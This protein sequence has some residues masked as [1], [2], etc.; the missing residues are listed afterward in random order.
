MEDGN[1]RVVFPSEE[2]VKSYFPDDVWLAMSGYEKMSYRNILHNYYVMKSLDLKPKKPPFL[3]LYQKRTFKRKPNRNMCPVSPK[4]KPSMRASSVNKGMVNKGTEQEKEA[5][6]VS[7]EQKTKQ[8]NTEVQ[9][10]LV[11]L[12]DENHRWQS[13]RAHCMLSAVFKVYK[14]YQGI[15]KARFSQKRTPISVSNKYSKDPKEE[16]GKID[17]KSNIHPNLTNRKNKEVEAGD[18]DNKEREDEN[19]SLDQ[20]KPESGQ[21]EEKGIPIS[22]PAATDEEKDKKNDEEKGTKKSVRVTLPRTRPVCRSVQTMTVADGCSPSDSALVFVNAATAKK[23]AVAP[24]KPLPLTDEQKKLKKKILKKKLRNCRTIQTQTVE[25]NDQIETA[26]LVFFPKPRVKKPK[27]KPSTIAAPN[28]EEPH[29]DGEQNDDSS[30]ADHSI[31]KTPNSTEAADTNKDI[32]VS[33]AD[34]PCTSANEKHDEDSSEDEFGFYDLARQ[35]KEASRCI[36]NLSIQNDPDMASKDKFDG[37]SEDEFGFYDL[38][39]LEK[40][41]RYPRRAVPV[42]NYK[43]SELVQDDEYLFCDFCD[44]EYEGD[45][46]EHGPHKY[47]PDKDIPVTGDRERAVETT[48]DM[49]KIGKSKIPGAGSGV[50]TILGL[51]PHVR[52]GP[53]QGD[54][55]SE[56]DPLGY[57]WAI[58]KDRKVDHYIA[59]HS[60]ATSNWMRFVN[61]ARHESEQNLMAFQYKGKMYYRTVKLIPPKAELFVWYGKEYAEMLGISMESFRSKDT[62]HLRSECLVLKPGIPKAIDPQITPSG[63]DPNTQSTSL[64][65]KPNIT[66][67]PQ[68]FQKEA[69]L[70][71][72]EERRQKAASLRAEHPTNLDDGMSLGAPPKGLAHPVVH[73]CLVFS[74]E[75]CNITYSSPLY[76][77][78]HEKKC[79]GKRTAKVVDPSRV[80]ADKQSLAVVVDGPQY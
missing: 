45:C 72:D 75:K 28:T 68:G 25:E 24:P 8:E 7:K 22:N 57:S 78:A 27:P 52:F 59:A 12:F 56:P 34:G 79:R 31:I 43:E 55:T 2:E 4:R 29:K 48:P 14:R 11:E 73:N 26:D 54:N 32:K 3:T 10:K 44:R 69:G 71:A 74:C 37:S 9:N 40:E 33:T 41:R 66:P 70:E 5:E 80:P 51:P 58:V 77:E 42:V 49:L 76:L 65:I 61:C 50:W 39:R 20:I 19:E 18:D 35:Q 15:S 46:P 67:G 16:D 36:I 13:I 21:I 17:C 38:A 6:H 30:L 63:L 64:P 60:T 47:Y 62:S 53:Y 23:L 1:N